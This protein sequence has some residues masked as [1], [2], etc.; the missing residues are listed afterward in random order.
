MFPL[1]HSNIFKRANVKQIKFVKYLKYTSS[2]KHS[3]SYF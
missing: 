2:L 3:K 1:S